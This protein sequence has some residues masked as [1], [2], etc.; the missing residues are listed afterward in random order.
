LTKKADIEFKTIL[1]FGYPADIIRD[2]AI[3]LSIDLI[4]MGT[5]GASGA[6]EFFLGSNAYNV[7]KNTNIPVLTIPGKKKVK[8][9]KKILFPIRAANG[10]LEKYNFIAPLIEKNQAELVILGLS[11]ESEIFNMEDRRNEIFELGRRLGL[12]DTSFRSQF[13]ICKNYAKKVLEI[14]RKEKADL[15]AINA[16]LDYNW[17]Q[18]FVGP[19]TQQ[20]VNHSKIPVLSY[21]SPGTTDTIAEVVK[22]EFSHYPKLK[23][24][25]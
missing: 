3:E 23:L 1:E 24:T 5:H 20:V 15:I 19:Y 11:L 6:R 25:L 4:V 9:F 7:I 21:R 18:F 12:N 8:E 2:K 13:F 14:A 17:R 10:I 22:E 16:S